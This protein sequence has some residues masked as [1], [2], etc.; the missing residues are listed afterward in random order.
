MSIR[1]VVVPLKAATMGSFFLVL[2][3]LLSEAAVAASLHAS[4]AF[5]DIQKPDEEHGTITLSDDRGGSRLRAE[6]HGLPEGSYDVE[7]H[8]GTSCEVTFESHPGPE[9]VSPLMPQAA[10]AAGPKIADAG[11]IAVSAKG[12][13]R[14]AIYLPLLT[15][16]ARFRGHA[17]VLRGDGIFCGVLE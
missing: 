10:G 3:G 12:T 14:E 4:I 9:G 17:V 1:T 15:G 11:V 8:E 5:V 7:V 2:G 16:V 6:L 13:A